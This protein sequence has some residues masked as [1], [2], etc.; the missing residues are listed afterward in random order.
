[1]PAAP[2]P[3]PENTST[4]WRDAYEGILAGLPPHER[5]IVHDAVTNG[6]IEGHTPDLESVARLADLATG[7]ITGEQYRAEALTRL[8]TPTPDQ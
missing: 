1:M 3:E 7:K 8:R 2:E 5:R 4:P 6:L